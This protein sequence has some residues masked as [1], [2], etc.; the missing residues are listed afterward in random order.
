MRCIVYES[1]ARYIDIEADVFEKLHETHQ[2]GEVGTSQ[3]YLE[4]T[5]IIE[6]LTGLPVCNTMLDETM[7]QITG[8]YNA[9]TAVAIL[10]Y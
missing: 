6:K 4:A 8:V 9:D 7:P 3:Q 2:K 5:N 10:E 1:R